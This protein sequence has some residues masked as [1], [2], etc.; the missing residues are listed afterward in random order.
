[1]KY[2]PMHPKTPS[3]QF[4]RQICRSERRCKQ[5]VDYLWSPA[6]EITKQA[7]IG[8]LMELGQVCKQN[9]ERQESTKKQAEKTE[10]TKFKWCK[11]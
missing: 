10:S 9:Q 4:T 6:K 1:M 2:I 7:V 11:M 5:F 8:V 3:T